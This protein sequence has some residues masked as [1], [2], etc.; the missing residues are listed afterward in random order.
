M[1]NYGAGLYGAGV[2]ETPVLADEQDT[3][4]P[5]I[6]VIVTGLIFYGATSITI[7]R[8]VAGVRTLLRGADNV[9]TGGQDVFVRDDA[10]L[11]FGIPVR[12]VAIISTPT[13]DVEVG[14]APITVTIEKVAITDAISGAAIQTVILAWPE[15]AHSRKASSFQVGGRTVVVS[16]QRSGFISTIDL[17]IETDSARENMDAL[18]RGATSGIIQ[19]RQDGGYGG[20]DSYVAVLG[21]SETRWSQDGSDPRRRWSLDVVQVEPWASTMQT[22][23][24]TLEDLANALDGETMLSYDTETPGTTL[25]DIALWDLGL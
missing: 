5:R 8:E 21:D 10:E 11:P 1:G 12:Y 23:G 18:L 22:R 24:W 4:P 16:G 20:V 13:G 7:Y 25:L 19:I 15:K 6:L 9:A 14:S 2:Y 17:V 3:W